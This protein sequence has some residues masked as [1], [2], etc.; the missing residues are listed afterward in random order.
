MAN[1][2]APGPSGVTSDALKSMTWTEQDPKEE[3]VDDDANFLGSTV[4]A[5]LVDFLGAPL[6]LSPGHLA[7]CPQSQ[8]TEICQT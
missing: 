8:R 3:G 2:K 1:K 4:H 6:I 7:L 5:V